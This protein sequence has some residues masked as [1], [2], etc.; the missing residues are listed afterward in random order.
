MKIL[1]GKELN[2]EEYIKAQEIALACDVTMDTAR[3][4]LYRNIDSVEKAKR[5]LSP[6]KEGFFNPFLLKGMQGAVDRI[7]K[8]KEVNENVLIFGDYD[9]DGVCATTVLKNCL[10]DFSI[11]PE[12]YIPERDEGY[13]LNVERVK[14]LSSEKRIDLLITVDCGISDKDKIE[15]LKSLGI[16]VIVT[17]HHE[18]PE[19]IPNC[20]CI[21][22]KI[23]GQKY[24]FNGL[25]GAG[26]AYKLGYAL[27]G[28]KADNYLDF[29]ALATVADS[30]DLISENRD[31][32]T[33]GLKLFNNTKSLRLP[34]KYLIGENTKQITA[35]T[36]MYTLA[37]RVNA[38]GR[39]GDAKCALDLFNE[40]DEQKIY[41]LA[42]KLN[43][44]N[45]ARQVACDDIYKEAKEKISA[46]KLDSRKII[47]V[48]DTNWKVGFVGIV[49]AK[50]VEDYSRPVIVFA[51]QDGHFKGSA[52]SVDGINIHDA[53]TEAKDLLVAFGGHSQAA[54]VAVE[55]K[56]YNALYDFLENY[57]NSLDFSTKEEKSIEV[58]MLIDYPISMRFA[59]EVDM[60]EPFGVGN[61][62]PIF[63]TQ[64]KE[65]SALPLKSGSLHYSFKTDVVEMLD[66]NGEK[67]VKPLILPINKTVL[68]E[69]NLSTFK[70][71]ESLKG[72]VKNIVVDFS[73]LEPIM[74]YIFAKKLKDFLPNS[75]TDND[76]FLDFE[77]VK[78]SD[79]FDKISVDREDFITTFNK[80]RSFSGKQFIDNA[81]FCI[82]YFDKNEIYQAILAAEV[83]IELGIFTVNNGYFTYCENIKNALTNSEVYS[84]IYT[85]KERYVRDI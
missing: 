71:R 44:Y 56:N 60:M 16:D 32:V 50:L 82:K 68:F 20:I 74:P 29:V 17:D 43:E 5:F 75:N 6:G 11:I 13:G 39:M 23:K 14:K 52:R 36:F 3:L 25:C 27:I 57:V 76:E 31:I 51:G 1:Y 62:R 28:K 61:R 38:G 69:L 65:I 49:A 42:V 47:L 22:P 18:P 59:R 24:P 53:L 7:R 26:V 83:F 73:D 45:L 35:Q 84:K 4:L 12:I 70:N 8:A 55:H 9:A 30:M 21:N 78:L 40:K 77:Q 19:E 66:F 37:P 58:D 72:F 2:N 10:A 63:A 33:E 15:E 81:T 64:V 54:G 85:E 67:D 79:F 80:L 34:F 48:G 41:E 46:E